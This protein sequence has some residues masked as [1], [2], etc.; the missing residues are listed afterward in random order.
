MAAALLNSFSL[1][2]VNFSN[3]RV[4]PADRDKNFNDILLLLLLLTV[5]LLAVKVGHVVQED[6]GWDGN[7]LFA[8]FDVPVR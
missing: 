8:A 3:S 5:V 4:K 1:D 6:V 7:F 2:R